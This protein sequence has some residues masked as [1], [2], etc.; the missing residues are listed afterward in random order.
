MQLGATQ[1]ADDLWFDQVWHPF[2]LSLDGS[3]REHYH[4]HWHTTPPWREAVDFFCQPLPSAQEL[5]E[6]AAESEA[7]L[8]AWRNHAAARVTPSPGLLGRLVTWWRRH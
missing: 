5:A 7:Y 6:D 2:W 3:Q 1:G 4:A 8:R